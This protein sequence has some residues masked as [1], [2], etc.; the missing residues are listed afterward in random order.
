VSTKNWSDL[1]KDAGETGSYEPLPDGD[2]DLVV[3]EATATTSQSGKTMFKLKAQV[4]GGAHNKRLVW[5]NLVVTP[6]S[7]A[8]LGMLFKK[9]HA[10]GIGRNYFDTNPTNAQIEATL[11]GR[12]FRAQIGSRMYNGAK[13]N[14]IRN[15]FPSAATIAAMQ[16]D[17]AAPAQAAAPAPASPPPTAAPAPAPAPVAAAPA[18]T[19]AAPSAPF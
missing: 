1:I 10:M 9:F 12:R 16:G 3:V 14:E 5:D 4:E 11:N 18:P 13:K 6:D 17:T 8:A 15:Y 2:Y 7:Q 19:P